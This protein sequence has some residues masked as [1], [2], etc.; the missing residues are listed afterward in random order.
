MGHHMSTYNIGKNAYIIYDTKAQDTVGIIQTTNT[1]IAAVRMFTDILADNSPGNTIAKHP[2]DF[3]LWCLGAL[4]ITT[5]KGRTGPSIKGGARLVFDAG[6][7]KIAEDRERAR[8][9]EP[10]EGEK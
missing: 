2:E 8:N 1:D 3:Q 7:W 5:E 9:T 4:T 10:K 6:A